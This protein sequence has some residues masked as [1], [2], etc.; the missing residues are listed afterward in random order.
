MFV[1]FVKITPAFA[2]RADLDR[3]E[4][5]C[6]ALIRAIE[7]IGEELATYPKRFVSQALRSRGV[8]RLEFATGWSVFFRPA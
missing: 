1:R 7:I 5:L 3:D 8:K 2:E 6:F 4:K